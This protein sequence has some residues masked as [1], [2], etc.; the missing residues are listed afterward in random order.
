[1]DVVCDAVAYAHRHGV[2]H[3]DLK[4]DNILLTRDGVLKIIDFGTASMVNR[5]LDNGYIMGTPAYMSPE[6][7]RGEV[8][9]GRT[10]LYALGIMTYEF[11]TGH[12]PFGDDVTF[13]DVVE[14]RRQPLSGLPES[15]LGVLEKATAYS[16]E[17][18]WPD[19]TTFH[20]A[21]VTAA[22]GSTAPP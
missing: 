17:D 3:N 21:F 6:Q 14:N 13:D 1:L 9:D 15:L 5:R 16:K 19:V 18:R 22:A 11:L 20:D 12:T 2:L 8:L 7:I 4:P 10:D